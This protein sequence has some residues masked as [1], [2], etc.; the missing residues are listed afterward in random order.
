M[1]GVDNMFYWYVFEDG[2]RACVKGYSKTELKHET[3]KHGKLIN[4]FMA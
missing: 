2:Y 4:K 3:R 1:K